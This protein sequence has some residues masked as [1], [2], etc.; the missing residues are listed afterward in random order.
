MKKIIIAALAF[1]TTIAYSQD[2]SFKVQVYGKGDPVILI[3]GLGCS[4]DMWKETVN[5]FKDHYQLYV[6]T[7]PG[8]AGVRPIDTPVLKTV[9][10]QLIN[11]VR[12]KRI[13]KP[14]LIGHSLGGF[15]SLWA[16]SEAPDLFSKIIC[17]DGYP[18]LPE[19]FSPGITE[20]QVKANPAYNADS[21]AGKYI[22]MPDPAFAENRFQM[23]L[24]MVKDS[25][26]A[27][28]ITKWNMQSD[29]KTL[30]YA[31]AEMC[32]KDLRNDISHINIPVLVLGATYSTKE[33]SKQMMEEQF[34]NLPHKLIEIAPTKHFIMYDDAAW[35]KEQVKNFLANGLY[36]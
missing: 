23:A 19:A 20:Q 7:L 10:D 16:A 1:A 36:N 27:K 31:Y 33:G 24:W 22:S 8:F 32:T 4:G 15:V 11:Y 9:R 5:N 13:A 29:R 14:V 30:A 34:K 18:F 25:T 35:F 28:M 21:V 26:Q 2:V 12:E 6:L 3:P 17:V